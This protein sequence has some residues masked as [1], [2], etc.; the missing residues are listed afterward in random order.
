MTTE[1]E[2][3]N[4]IE[5]SREAC[6]RRAC[7]RRA[8]IEAVG[9][10][11]LMVLVIGAGVSG[12]V[13][14]S[15]AAIRANHQ[16]Y[17]RGLA[18][19]AA[20]QIDPALHAA[21]QAPHQADTNI[22][23]ETVAPLRR[24]R[25]SI[26]ELAEAYT[27]VLDG[28]AVRFVVDAAEPGDADG[29]GIDDRA[30]VWEVY[31]DVDPDLSKALGL[32]G[33]RPRPVASDV[34]HGDKW[35]VFMSGYAPFYDKAGEFAGIVGLDVD[36]SVYADRMATARREATLGFVPSLALILLLA[37]VYYR[38]R[39]RS[40]IA[41]HAIQA[42]AARAEE[43]ATVLAAERRR[44]GNVIDATCVGTWEWYIATGE[45]RVNDR[46]ASMIGI[47][48]A[49]SGTLTA[50]FLRSLVHPDDA[51]MVAAGFKRS[52]GGSSVTWE[53]EYRIRHQ[54][55]RWIWTSVRGS[56]IERN[57][58]GSPLVMAG[59][60][61]DIT[62]RK[63]VDS[64]LRES[65]AR[66]RGFFRHSPIGI[67]LND[68]TTGS[69]LDANDAMLAAIGY[70]RE[71]IV[72]L[73]Y[74]DITPVMYAEQ[75]EF[76]KN[77]LQTT[78]RYGPYEK[79]YIRRDG[80][81]I[82]VVLSGIRVIEND[83]RGV[84][85][86]IV[87]DISQRKAL[88]S[89]LTD[90]ASRDRLTSLANRSLFMERLQRAVLRHRAGDKGHFAV[91]FLDFDNFKMIN[92]AMGHD[93]GDALLREVADRLCNTLRA[94]DAL[95]G[96]EDDNLVARFGGDEFVILIHDLVAGT[97]AT[98]LAERLLNALAPSYSIKGRDVHCSASIGI[99]TSDQ[100]VESADSIVRNADV[101]MYEAKRL[102][103][104][105]SV[106]FNEAMHTRLTRHL[107]I[108]S[109]LRKALGGAEMS[110]HY[111]PIVELDSGRMISV[112]ALIRW[113]HPVLGPVSPGEF[114]PV[115]EQ[116]GLIVPLGAWVLQEACRQLVEWRRMRPDFAPAMVTVNVS[117]AEL[118]LGDEL[119]QRV[120]QTLLQTGLP[121]RCLQLEVTEREVMRDPAATRQLMNQLRAIGVKLAMD[122]FGTGTS[123]L[124]CLRDYPFD[125]IKIDRSF[126]SDL[127]NSTDGMAVIHAT[128]TLVE[129]LGM[130]SVAEGVETAA[131]VAI[132]QSLGCR[133][134]QGF[135]FS[136]P[137]PATD[138][139]EAL[140]RDTEDTVSLPAL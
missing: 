119:L 67:A 86:S 13:L 90:A 10:G 105:C 138:L 107:T 80:S 127:A 8:G 40:M 109:A 121:P 32:D 55:G 104:N 71:E 27:M 41:G 26:P 48:P 112:E 111:Q 123:S 73:A 57:A 135:Y 36:A 140:E 1:A 25:Q 69:F 6:Q 101:A 30:A 82:P 76:H 9:I 115:A 102:G 125:T 5:Q 97:D 43:A 92:D 134:A 3:A 56:V 103:R 84:I 23:N 129:N 11:I 118:A 130:T 2:T 98:K 74:R 61:Q 42:A 7:L 79:E 49:E 93:A 35:G 122:D 108:E 17:L 19:A 68:L 96:R 94:G 136:R 95:G 139:F 114:I 132:L 39:S 52:F 113:N 87:Q 59:T 72:N 88:E 75:D 126:V 12:T 47:N 66:F 44:L 60:N 29:D 4:S 99:V 100:G 70:R 14:T 64:A 31:E 62:A 20:Q 46:F 81:R 106:V 77:Q 85:W 37:I 133:Y 91:M 128:I 50:E 18:V 63:Q 65:E 22:Y 120:R 53:I 116:S 45:V 15:V 137:V 28:D 110:L 89:Q 51:A 83:G 124:A 38:I 117:R 78:G 16:E 54:D 131:Q 33:Q 24:L 58:D 21:I 34:P